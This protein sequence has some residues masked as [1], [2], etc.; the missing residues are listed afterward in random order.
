MNKFNAALREP[1][2][3]TLVA[4]GCTAKIIEDVFGV[5]EGTMTAVPREVAEKLVNDVHGPAVVKRR[6]LAKLLHVSG[7][8][9]DFH[10][11]KGRLQRVMIP[12]SSRSWGYS[13]ASV[14][15]FL[16]ANGGEVR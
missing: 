3:T 6:D 15:A 10:A 12:G 7:K 4:G 11:R 16:A 2:R 14:D 9:L 5:V 1:V 8:T 13:R